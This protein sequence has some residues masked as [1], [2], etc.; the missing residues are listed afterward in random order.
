MES[1]D[2]TSYIAAGLVSLLEDAVPSLD[3][4]VER[5]IGAGMEEK[6]AA[7]IGKALTAFAASLGRD[8]T[9]SP[10]RGGGQIRP[11]ENSSGFDR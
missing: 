1:P 2:D 7:G 11:P 5:Y 4:L 10:T 9:P 3:A 8:G 6:Q